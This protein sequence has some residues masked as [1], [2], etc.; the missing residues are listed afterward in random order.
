MINRRSL[1]VKAFKNLYAY[2]SSKGANYH[3]ALDRINEKFSPDLN[4]M[5]VADKD[6]LRRKKELALKAIDQKLQK[7]N[8][9]IA[10]EVQTEVQDAIE[11]MHQLNKKD[12][13]N[14]NLNL[15]GEADRVSE[16]HIMIL[17]VV[18]EL[19]F[20]NKKLSD[21]KKSLAN[22]LGEKAVSNTNLFQNRV[23]E[24]LRNDQAFQKQKIKFKIHWGNHA[25]SLRDWYKGILKKDETYKE[26]CKKE[27]PDYADDWDIVDYICRVI[28]L[29]ND[30]FS[31]FFED[32]DLDWLDNKHIVKSLVQK[33]IKSLKEEESELQLADISY[34]WE[35]DSAYVQELFEK[36]VEQNDYIES[37]LREKLQNWDIDR[38]ALTDKVLL[39][40]A[41]AEML[42]FPSIPTKVTIN[43]FIEISK[44]FSTPKSKSFLNGI[45]D[46]L[47]I[48][49]KERGIIRKSGRG[50]LDNK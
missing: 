10:G 34:N 22:V 3:L 28:V 7:E 39:K 33:T 12:F 19:A 49:L 31:G 2:E 17:S 26:Y 27:T 9:E 5:E 24:K 14:L 30:V 45:L 11:F 6:D 18:E 23:V 44:V 20:V 15:T 25:D 46:T 21:E 42:Y 8:G 32:I 13:K 16:D 4:S 35:D 38:V 43:E 47:A 29:K 1:R 48:D 37:L 50:L 36:T 40:L 41:I